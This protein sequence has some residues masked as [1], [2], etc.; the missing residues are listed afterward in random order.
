[1]RIPSRLRVILP[2][3]V[4]VAC[5]GLLMVWGVSDQIKPGLW[6]LSLFSG[7]VLFAPI[8]IPFIF[9]PP[10]VDAYVVSFVALAATFAHPLFR[11]P[12]AAAVTVLGLLTWLLSELMVI[13]TTT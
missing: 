4:I 10:T 3:A 1:M 12:W 7:C 2:G 8:C 5:L 9:H 6:V 13:G 11:R